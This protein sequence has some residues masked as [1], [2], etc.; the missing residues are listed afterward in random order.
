M[1]LN[2]LKKG[3]FDSASGLKPLSAYVVVGAVLVMAAAR[4]YQLSTVEVEAAEFVREIHEER[5]PENYR[6]VD[7]TGRVLAASMPS[8]DLLLSPQ[9]VWQNHTPER[10]SARIA[11][12]LGHEPEFGKWLMDAML[13]AGEGGWRRVN[14]WPLSDAEA[15]RLGN[16]VTENEMNGFSVE[17][18]DATGV[19]YL[20]WSPR[21]VLSL[22]ERAR[23]FERIGPSSWT[24]HLARGIWTARHGNLLE[25]GER[26]RYDAKA[27]GEEVWEALLPEVHS[28]PITRITPTHAML[29]EAALADEKVS[30]DHMRLEL[31]SDR[32]HPAG[33]FPTLGNWGFTKVG[34]E[35]PE[36]YV[37]LELYAQELCERYGEAWADPSTSTYE[38]IAGRVSR[39]GATPYY[40]DSSVAAPPMVVESTIDLQLQRRLHEQLELAREE[41]KAVLA[42]G[43]IVHVASGEVL[44]L[45]A[46]SSYPT[47]A[48]LPVAHL[49]TPGSTFKL[50]TMAMGLD[51]GVVDPDSDVL[52]VGRF[53]VGNG[54]EWPIPTEFGR[55]L[56]HEALGAPS[57]VI[58]LAECLARS[59]NAGMIQVGVQLSP[60][61]FRGKL[62]ELGYGKPPKAGLGG[63]NF[64]PLKPLSGW[65]VRN[66]Q[67]S[68]SFGHNVA[69]SLWQ[70]AENL[71]AILRDGVWQ[72]LVLVRAIEQGDRRE[73]VPSERGAP[74]RVFAPGVGRIVRDMM[75][76]GAREGTGEKIVRDDI[77]MGTKTGT[78]WKEP[79]VLPTAVE[80]AALAKHIQAGSQPTNEE[81]RRERKELARLYAGPQE[82]YTSSV[83]A[84]GHLPGQSIEDELMVLIVVDEPDKGKFGSQV[85]GPTAVTLLAEALGLTKYGEEKEVVLEGDFMPLELGDADVDAGDDVPW[86]RFLGSDDAMAGEAR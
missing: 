45:D 28:V 13:P 24:R 54:R 79:G 62:V 86:M 23:H 47:R 41:H 2:P 25:N 5:A 63:E 56:V 15:E 60:E 76:L 61:H 66:E 43:I 64:W 52:G 77:E 30:R 12:A 80:M 57:G 68:I 18:D 26:V 67:V 84:V 81:W 4:L 36:A 49:F 65:R 7:R 78:T 48:F 75:T 82:A 73:L 40:L 9:V 85:A 70:H 58:T 72:P 19:P 8:Y 38:W 17:R 29:V 53:D 83:V 11:E 22:A 34:Q 55:R 50:V 6:I 51:A 14:A 37:G 3:T 31:R 20:W 16:W 33:E 74:R 39:R 71:S 59:S 46:V 27:A 44:A 10:I 69:V 35:T 21:E 1:K 32:E 42:M